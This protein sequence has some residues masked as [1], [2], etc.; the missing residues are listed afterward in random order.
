M[1]DSPGRASASAG[2]SAPSSPRVRLEP[3]VPRVD[4]F[5]RGP[6]PSDAVRRIKPPAEAGAHAPGFRRGRN[7]RRRELATRTASASFAGEQQPTVRPPLKRTASTFDGEPPGDVYAN[8]FK[9]VQKQIQ[10]AVERADEALLVYEVAETEKQEQLQIELDEQGSLSPLRLTEEDVDEMIPAGSKA[11]MYHAAAQ[12]DDAMKKLLKI[13]RDLDPG[14]V[15]EPVDERVDDFMEQFKGAQELAG[16]VLAH[17]DVLQA[18]VTAAQERLLAH[19]EE[20]R[21]AERKAEEEMGLDTEVS[22]SSPTARG[23]AVFAG[24][25]GDPGADAH[26]VIELKKHVK[27]LETRVSDL[28]AE[29]SEEHERYQDMQE[30]KDELIDAMKLQLS[31]ANEQIE[32]VMGAT[33]HE[34]ADSAAAVEDTR[35]HIAYLTVQLRN[36]RELADKRNFDVDKWVKKQDFEAVVNEATSLKLQV[37]KLID[38]VKAEQKNTDEAHSYA[39]KCLMAKERAD[40]SHAEW[41][42]K[43]RD[44]LKARDQDLVTLNFETRLLHNRADKLVK[45]VEET[46]A[47]LEREKKEA[48]EQALSAMEEQ[49]QAF[50]G[51]LAERDK[52]IAQLKNENRDLADQ[53]AATKLLHDNLVADLKKREEERIARQSHRGMMTEAVTFDDSAPMQRKMN[54]GKDAASQTSLVQGTMWKVLRRKFAIE[55]LARLDEQAK[56]MTELETHLKGL[57]EGIREKRRG[58]QD[59]IKALTSAVTTG[60]RAIPHNM[61]RLQDCLFGL[62]SHAKRQSVALE[63]QS[64]LRAAVS[65]AV[66]KMKEEMRMTLESDVRDQIEESRR[67]LPETDEEAN[68]V[69]ETTQ[70]LEQIRADLDQMQSGNTDIEGELVKL[71][72]ELSNLLD[73]DIM[74]N[75]V[76]CRSFLMH[77]LTISQRWDLSRHK[78]ALTAVSTGEF[79]DALPSSTGSSVLSN[80][81]LEESAALNEIILQWNRQKSEWVKERYALIK[82]AN[83]LRK[84]LQSVNFEMMKGDRPGTQSNSEGASRPGTMTRQMA[85]RDMSVYEWV[86]FRSSAGQL[87]IEIDAITKTIQ[88]WWQQQDKSYDFVYIT[89][90]EGV[91][92]PPLYKKILQLIQMAALAY[93]KAQSEPEEPVTTQRKVE[94]SQTGSQTSRESSPVRLKSTPL[95]DVV[96]AT[97][98]QHQTCNNKNIKLL[99]TNNTAMRKAVQGFRKT[100]VHSVAPSPEDAAAATLQRA[101]RRKY[102]HAGPD[103]LG[104]VVISNSFLRTELDDLIKQVQHAHQLFLEDNRQVLKGANSS[105][106]ELEKQ[107][108]ELR[109]THQVCTSPFRCLRCAFE[110]LTCV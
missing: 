70:K 106:I 8:Q 47:R 84:E 79:A 75:V 90:G 30:S 49:R 64:E 77:E 100:L 42:L 65:D 14:A 15:G 78:K 68:V 54:E 107:L 66:V 37:T 86:L 50:N 10:D 88:S 99:H 19:Q 39:K 24:T 55:S 94:V 89:A 6:P 2:T 96:T 82:E 81:H 12:H 51:I 38:R 20:V 92:V 48:V 3:F 53:F 93:N 23:E 85:T 7:P 103:F 63:K 74:Q 73:G 22:A 98:S 56:K 104:S 61:Q 97:D 21:L 105:S 18:K 1:P 83:D 91:T 62:E 32:S 34:L 80:P 52:L 16:D 57:E 36:A 101:A 108:V 60:F 59:T 26:K 31:A 43:L 5:H 29:V 58:S 40:A 13:Y 87:E 69:E 17:R 27:M 46:K 72:A 67:S 76:S 28:Q 41:E 4:P 71:D 35:L 110:S 25:A 9:A 95:P 11:A 109:Q 44:T 45:E 102:G 33:A